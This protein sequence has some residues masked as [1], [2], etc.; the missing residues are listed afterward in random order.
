MK[1]YPMSDAVC[2][3][4]VKGDTYWLAESSEHSLHKE[5]KVL[6]AMQSAQE[7]PEKILPRRTVIVVRNGVKDEDQ[8]E[9]QAIRHMNLLRILRDDMIVRYPPRGSSIL[10]SLTGVS[11]FT[12]TETKYLRCSAVSIIVREQ[13]VCLGMS[14]C[15]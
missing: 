13:P 4:S 14:L 9:L 5:V 12:S 1:L 3:P 15:M 10:E 7:M 8:K 2:Y 11:G 6:R